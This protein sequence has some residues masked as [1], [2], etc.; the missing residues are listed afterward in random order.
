MTRTWIAVGI[1]TLGVF[2]AT[3]VAAARYEGR[4]RRE[5]EP[6]LDDPDQAW[7]WR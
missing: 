3:I 4:H 7:G 1:A 2:A 6:L 5:H